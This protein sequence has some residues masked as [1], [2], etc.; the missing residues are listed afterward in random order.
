[1][2]RDVTDDLHALI[3]SILVQLQLA[4]RVVNGVERLPRLRNRRVAQID[5]AS[6]E[7]GRRG[8]RTRNDGGGGPPGLDAESQRHVRHRGRI[9]ERRT[10]VRGKQGL[11]GS[12]ESPLR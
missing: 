3:D 6:M 11:S 10:K 12:I 2:G 9:D 4:L 8:R 5:V 7:D 1:R